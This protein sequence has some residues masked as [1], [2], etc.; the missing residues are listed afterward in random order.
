M[1]CVDPADLAF[2]WQARSEIM[3]ESK[4][5]ECM[6]SKTMVS[7]LQIGPFSEFHIRSLNAVR[8]TISFA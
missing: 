8:S 7:V 4:C 5:Q 6:H 1:D 3:I 2:E